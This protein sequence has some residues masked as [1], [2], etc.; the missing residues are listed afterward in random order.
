MGKGR[1]REGWGR[2]EGGEDEER[3]EWPGE[4]LYLRDGALLTESLKGWDRGLVVEGRLDEGCVGY[5]WGVFDKM[6]QGLIYLGR[7]FITAY[8]SNGTRQHLYIP[9][10]SFSYNYHPTLRSNQQRNMQL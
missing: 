8:T 4:W 9:A 2:G 5:V 6:R 3:G 10:P 1:R 7:C